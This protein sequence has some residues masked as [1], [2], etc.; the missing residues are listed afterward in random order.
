V[1]RLRL[2][3]AICGFVLAML[4]VAL[5][6]LRLVWGA[7]AVLLGSLLIRLIL[8]QRESGNSRPKD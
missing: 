2:G 6:D 8:R 7:I 3:L 4:G 1:S 5:D